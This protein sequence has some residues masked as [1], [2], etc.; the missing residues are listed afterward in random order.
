MA[1]LREKCENIK[2][3]MCRTGKYG[4]DYFKTGDWVYVRPIDDADA[5][6][7]HGHFVYYDATTM[8]VA[9]LLDSEELKIVPTKRI[10]YMTVSVKK[11]DSTN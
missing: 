3:D 2:E 1:K 8:T 10:E 9:I 11:D 5:G 4:W 6:G 7:Y